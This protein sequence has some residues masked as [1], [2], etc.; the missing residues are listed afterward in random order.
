[1]GAPEYWTQE[2]IAK[3]EKSLWEHVENP[4]SHDILEWRG[5]NKLT[6][7]TVLNL[8]RKDPDF[9]DSYES[10]KAILGSRRQKAALVG[11]WHAGTVQRDD[12][13]YDEDI[14]ARQDEIRK[15]KLASAEKNPFMIMSE[16]AD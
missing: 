15:E 12:W 9:G 13:A 7:Q 5:K 10:A 2:R 16:N 14:K 6:R 11:E 1:M 4:E 3:V 8:C